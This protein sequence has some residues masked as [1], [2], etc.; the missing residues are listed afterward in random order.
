M[1]NEI[2]IIILVIIAVFVIGFLI[3]SLTTLPQNGGRTL[4]AF[5]PIIEV[6]PENLGDINA[7]DECLSLVSESDKFQRELYKKEWVKE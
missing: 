6:S 2:L 1:K 4:P 3:G 5:C 7:F